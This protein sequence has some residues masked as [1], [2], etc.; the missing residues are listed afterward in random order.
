MLL[1]AVSHAS[2]SYHKGEQEMDKIEIIRQRF[3][4]AQNAYSTASGASASYY[5]GK[6]VG[7]IE[8]VS[9]LMGISWIEADVLLRKTE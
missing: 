1:L 2:I 8:A 3:Q 6:I 9:Y 7:M 5:E 4:E